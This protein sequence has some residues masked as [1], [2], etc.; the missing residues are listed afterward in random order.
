MNKTYHS[1][2]QNYPLSYMHIMYTLML[3]AHQL[4]HAMIKVYKQPKY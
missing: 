2:T 4:L 3:H 1:L